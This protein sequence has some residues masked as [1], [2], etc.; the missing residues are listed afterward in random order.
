MALLLLP[1]AA[2]QSGS[3][4]TVGLAVAAGVCLLCGW[5]SEGLAHLVGRSGTPLVA[6]LTGMAVRMAPPLVIC[7]VLAA[8]G[9]DGRG[10]LAFIG[11]LLTF[12]MSTL[13]VETWLAVK[14][15]SRIPSDSNQGT[16]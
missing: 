10:H 14:R 6:M 5:T 3:A 9:T 1:F 4:G 12:Y 8:Q 7:L 16:R 15:T 13:A 2:R 11:Y